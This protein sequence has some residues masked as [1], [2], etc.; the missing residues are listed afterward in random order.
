MNRTAFYAA[1]RKR[2]SGVFGTSLSQSQV[3]GLERL[4][5]A[6]N[7]RPVS[8]AA[9]LLATAYHETGYTMQPIREAFGKTDGDTINRLER[10]WK[11]GKMPQVRTPYWRPDVSGKAWF[12]RGYVQLSHLDNYRKA[13]AITGVDLL[14]DPSRAMN[15]EVAA[16]ILVD[17]SEVGLFTGKRLADY[18][19]GDYVGARRVINGQD[20]AQQI[21]TYAKTF[22]KALVAAGYS[23]TA[24]SAKPITTPGP[25]VPNGNPVGWSIG[26][27][28][29]AAGAVFWKFACSVPVLAGLFSIC[30]N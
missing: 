6:V 1:L 9:Y 10:A 30:G 17:G 18:L 4:L 28:I 24:K 8:H 13:A 7:G 15:P 25:V 23:V 26:V 16:K 11:A 27:L 19:P 21:A 2:D 12:G 5:S 20:R 14:G 29:A 3:D 22:E